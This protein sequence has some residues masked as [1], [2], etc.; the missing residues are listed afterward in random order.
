[1]TELDDTYLKVLLLLSARRAGSSEPRRGGFWHGLADILSI[2]QE[3]RQGPEE[4]NPRH[5]AVLQG[6][7]FGELHAV[8]DELRRDIDTLE[9]EYRSSYGQVTPI[10]GET[11]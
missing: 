7:E 11:P 5:V 3:R 9:V 10:T 6:D 4:V 2:E 8:L 1:M